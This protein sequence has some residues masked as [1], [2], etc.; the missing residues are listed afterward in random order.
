M[1][2]HVVYIRVT[3]VDQYTTCYLVD[4]GATFDK[5]FTGHASTG[6][7]RH[8][9]RNRIRFRFVDCFTGQLLRQPFFMLLSV[10]N[11]AFFDYIFSSEFRFSIGC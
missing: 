9:N 10:K 4:A 5:T 3:F 6:G 2:A 8:K 1:T 7:T 11:S